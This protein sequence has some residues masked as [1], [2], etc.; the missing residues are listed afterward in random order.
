MKSHRRNKPFRD[1]VSP[2]IARVI[3]P[4]PVP[5][6]PLPHIHTPSVQCGNQTNPSIALIYFHGLGSHFN[7]RYPGLFAQHLLP[8]C[9]HVVIHGFDLSGHG[10][11]DG[12]RLILDAWPSHIDVCVQFVEK[13]RR[14]VGDGVNWCSWE[15]VWEG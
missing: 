5:P 15:R 6:H 14:E 10:R 3:A 7:Q 9:P 2:F 4:R 11:S 13:V 1:F 8:S 12:E